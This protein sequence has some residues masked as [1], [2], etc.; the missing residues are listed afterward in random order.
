MT[1]S[2]VN[3]PPYVALRPQSAVL[4]STIVVV[5]I[6]YWMLMIAAIGLGATHLDPLQC[7]AHPGIP[8][9][10]ILL[11]V[12][13]LFTLSLGY[14]KSAWKSDLTVLSN[15]CLSAF[16]T[17]VTFSILITGS[18]FVYSVY[19]PDYDSHESP[20]YCDRVTY[21]FAF[22]LTTLLWVAACLLFFCACCFV[23]ITCCGAVGARGSLLPTRSSFYGATNNSQ[24]HVAGDV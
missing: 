21:Q 9:Y 2:D 10:L 8:V 20:V 6:I 11:G 1:M 7:R 12:F 13:S 16:L 4:I 15:T 14:T 5:N 24:E 3:P 22:V 19:P 18:R 17:I 23:L